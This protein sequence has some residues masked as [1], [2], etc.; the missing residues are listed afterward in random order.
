MFRVAIVCEGPVDR[1]IIESTLDHY[2]EDYE[3]FPIQ[4]PIANIG[5]DSG[6]FGGGWKGVRTWANQEAMKAGGLHHH[7]LDNADLLLIQ[8]DADV[9]LDSEIS[10]ERPCPPPEDNCD[11]VRSLL[12][13]WLGIENIPDR[14][15]FCVPS[16]CSETWVLAGLFPEDS[17]VTPCEPPPPDGICI[18][19]RRDV[20]SFLRRLASRF[21][22]KLVVSQGGQLKNQAK[23]YQLQNA[24]IA[25][26][27]PSV[28]EVCSAAWRFDSDLQNYLP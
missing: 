24:R 2:L 1:V 5:G 12:L 14:V 19:C 3:M 10:R 20:K 21:P 7:I 15:V 11:E 22:V 17:S 4:P 16:M 26:G 27:W 18:E 23:G 28:I 6:P 25:K 9:A 13:E 8:I